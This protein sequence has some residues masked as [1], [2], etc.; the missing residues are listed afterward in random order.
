MISVSSDEGMFTNI[1]V[2]SNECRFILLFMLFIV[3]FWMRLV[4]L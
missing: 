1:L 3:S 2:M 4:L